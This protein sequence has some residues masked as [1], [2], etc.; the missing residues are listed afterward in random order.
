MKPKTSR[1]R[2]QGC[3]LG[4]LF[5][6]ALIVVAG[7]YLR[8]YMDH[9]GPALV[10]VSHQV[11]PPAQAPYTLS[12]EQQQLV[13]KIGY[14]DSF[15]LLFYQDLD[16]QDQAYDIRF[17]CWDYGAAGR[18]V[19]F[20][21]GEMVSDE[22]AEAAAQALVASPYRPEQFGASMDLKDVLAS[23]GISEYVRAAADPALVASGE[24][25][26]ASQL[27][28]GMKAGH[29]MAVETVPLEAEG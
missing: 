14:P 16:E 29:L 28:F 17:E 1:V 6:V 26:F 23:T 22:P 19:V 18:D 15:T 4:I 13:D 25:Y 3:V 10:R 7:A 9:T 8:L 2:W 24:V 5:I 21:N 11:D 20:V 27:T 12:T